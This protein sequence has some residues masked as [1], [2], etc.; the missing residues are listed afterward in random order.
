MA[1]KADFERNYFLDDIPLMDA[2]ERFERHVGAIG[3]SDDLITEFV[4]LRESVG[5]VSANAIF[6]KISSPHVTTSAMDGIAIRFEASL[7][8]TETRPLKLTESDF[9]WVDTGDP[10]P[11]GFDSV[12]MIEDIQKLSDNEV[13]IRNPVAPYQH[14]RKIAEDIAAPELLVRG[15]VVIT[16]L[17]LACLGAA[18]L[19][20]IEVNREPRVSLIPTGSELIKIGETPQPG[21]IIEFNSV[22]LSALIEDW[23]AKAIVEPSVLDDPKMMEKTLLECSDRSDVLVV[24]A[25]SS[26]GSEDY[27]STVVSKVGEV[28]VHGVAIRP[29]H[30]V[31]L[32]SIRGKPLLGIPGYPSSALTTSELFL[33]PLIAKLCGYN[34]ASAER[35][36]AIMARKIASPLGEEEFLRVVAAPVDGDYVV[37]PTTRGAA[38]TLSISRSDGVITIPHNHEGLEEG[39]EVSVSLRR[40][41]SEIDKTLLISGSHDIAIDMLANNLSGARN[42]VRLIS[43]SVGS[44]G[45]LLALSKGFAHVA[46]TH[47]LDEKSGEYNISAVQRHVPD[48][49]VHIFDFVGRTQGLIVQEGNPRKIKGLND[50]PCSG[51]KI[52]NR[53]RGSGT[54]VLLDYLLKQ[55][56][57]SPGSIIGYDNEEYTHYNVAA[58]VSSGF[59]DVGMGIMAAA[60]ASGLEFIPIADERFQ[61]VIPSRYIGIGSEIDILLEQ[62]TGEDLRRDIASIGGYDVS[63]MGR[64]AARIN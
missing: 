36:E 24:I 53:Q 55:S 43:S 11:T 31:I 33:K 46:G 7:G 61:L 6:A 3:V 42:G 25:G 4:P 37:H 2:K 1:H 14:I 27:T 45:G 30:P 44:V 59:V 39:A 8:A 52:V 48:E 28:V 5:R 38:M 20:E 63:R 41:R 16:A 22:F 10:I 12:V 40:P 51:L 18:G 50:L 34:E 62:L 35:I 9:E 29:G 56:N 60:L 54:R 49:S 47:L 32:G 23:G 13:V 17:D 19:S 58:A 64:I 15:G 26:A 21:Q 57:I